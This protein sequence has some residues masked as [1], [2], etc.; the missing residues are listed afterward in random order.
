MPHAKIAVQNH[1][2]IIR[3]LKRRQQDIGGFGYRF[4]MYAHHQIPMPSGKPSR[5]DPG[6]RAPC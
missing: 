2:G 4:T 3:P 5:L 6:G 1:D